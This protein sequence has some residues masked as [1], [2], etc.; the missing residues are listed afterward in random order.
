[1][2]EYV[3]IGIIYAMT[4]LFLFLWFWLDSKKDENYLLEKVGD[5]YR[6]IKKIKSTKKDKV[7]RYSGKTFVLMKEGVAS[8]SKVIRYL[9]YRTGKILKFMGDKSKAVLNPEEMDKFLSENFIVQSL[10][11]MRP[12]SM[13][14]LLMFLLP[15]LALVGGI[16]M[17]YIMG[18]MGVPVPVEE[19]ATNG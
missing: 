9:D 10:K 12:L 2:I 14:Q 3:I 1:M 15:V 6:L 18:S 5:G 4:Y 17:G 16:I 8:G 7:V 11:A 19:V 13:N